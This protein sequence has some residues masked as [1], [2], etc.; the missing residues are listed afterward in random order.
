MLR[1]LMRAGIRIAD[2]ELRG[3]G[4]SRPA[5]PHCWLV[6]GSAARGDLLHLQF[7]TLAAVYDDGSPA[8]APEDSM[9]FTAVAGQ[10]AEWFHELGLSGPGFYWPEGARPSMPLSE[11]Q[12]LY[13]ETIE[14]PEGHDV[15]ARREFFDVAL[16]AG[17]EDVLGGLQREIG[18][19]FCSHPESRAVLARA[20]LA[21]V[22][23]LT[24][25]QGL[26]LGMDGSRQ[27]SFNVEESILSPVAQAARLFVL[28]ED[29]GSAGTLARLEA[30]GL[31]FGE[32]EPVVRQAAE[33]F[34]VGLFYRKSA[35]NA[36]ISPRQL[37]KFDQLLLKRAFESV[38]GFLSL[39]GSI[40]CEG[41]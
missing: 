8:M 38:R 4:F 18:V 26:V 19:Q 7:P 27:E 13:R 3:A 6:F 35:G 36:D 17:D 21:H 28:G 39:T 16:V 1:E 31:R 9:Y 5:V 30:A 34:R 41:Q 11:W 32:H 12:R 33:A 23:P 15:Y 20:T 29:A 40:F 10:T 25:F 24:F 37:Q 14:D 22:P 2:L